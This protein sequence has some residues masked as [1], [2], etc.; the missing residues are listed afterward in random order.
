MLRYNS[1]CYFQSYCLLTLCTQ[2]FQLID[3]DECLNAS[4]CEQICTN[5]DG[6][7]VCGCLSGYRLIEDTNNCAGMSL[8]MVQHY[9]Y[10]VN[11]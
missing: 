9:V 1:Y 10:N 7:F 6:S 4:N 2:Y 3:I 11:N 8:S 5:T